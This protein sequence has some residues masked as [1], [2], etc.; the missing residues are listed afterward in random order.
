MQLDHIDKRIIAH[1]QGDL[2]LTPR[3]FL[4]LAEELGLS[5]GEV[6]A[7]L[8]RLAE[9]RVMRRFGATLRHQKS[10]FASNVMVAWRVPD[11]AAHEVGEKLSTFR[12]VSHCYWRKPCR[13]FPYNLFSMVHGTSEEECRRLVEDMAAAVGQPEHELL[14]SLEELKKTSMRYFDAEGEIHGS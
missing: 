13:D 2:P 1:L 10:G 11:E 7:R 4:P 6:V 14:F 9:T 12:R 8:R 5:E 3:P